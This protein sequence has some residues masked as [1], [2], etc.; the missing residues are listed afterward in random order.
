[1]KCSKKI[2]GA[3]HRSMIMS[4][5]WRAGDLLFVNNLFTLHD[6]LP[7]QGERRMLRVRYDD[8]LNSR[9]RY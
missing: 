5:T 3:V 6:R 4:H 1:M 2:D 7:F 9:M 8:P